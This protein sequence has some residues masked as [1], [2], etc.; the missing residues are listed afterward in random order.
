M[1]KKF[2]HLEDVTGQNQAK[3]SVV[4]GIRSKVIEQYPS[5]E[6]YI[7]DILPKK[8]P[9]T[10]IKCRDHIELVSVQTDLLFF[11]QRDGPYIPTLRLL[12]KYPFMLP[13]LQVDRGAIKFILSG[14]NIMCPGLTS[15]GAK[16][17]TDLPED[18]IVAIMAE[19]KE[20]SLC[21]GLTKMTTENIRLVNKGIAVES[22]HYL[23]DGLWDMKEA[24]R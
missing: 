18:T 9:V 22:I 17:E 6:Q 11:K 3:S 21:I 19:G 1:F 24:K 4:R 13:W 12:H 10:V 14:A 2:S 20:H 23:C 7:D 8:E 16:M 15:Q 5:I